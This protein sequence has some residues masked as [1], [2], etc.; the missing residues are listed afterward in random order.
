MGPNLSAFGAY[1][2]KGFV[3]AFRNDSLQNIVTFIQRGRDIWTAPIN[4]SDNASITTSISAI[5]QDVPMSTIIPVLAKSARGIAGGSATATDPGD[6]SMVLAS[7]T[8]GTATYYVPSS[9]HTAKALAGFKKDAGMFQ[10]PILDPFSPQLY[11]AANVNNN[12]RRISFTGY[13]I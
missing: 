9:D 7:D 2:Y 11:W 10:V 8:G 12:H 5:P 4:M 6:C 13:S 3:S 1:Q